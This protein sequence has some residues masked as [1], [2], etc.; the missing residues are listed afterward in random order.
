M[1][2]EVHSIY[3]KVVTMSYKYQFLILNKILTFTH[4]CVELYGLWPY[5]I[6]K[7]NRQIKYNYSKVIYSIVLPCILLSFFVIA[8]KSFFK[9]ARSKMGFNG[10]IVEIIS[11]A[12][13]FLFVISYVSV[14]IGQHLESNKTKLAYIK[15]VE[16]MEYLKRFPNHSVDFRK[17]L[18]YF[19]LKALVLELLFFSLFWFNLIRNTQD[20]HSNPYLPLLMY[21]P[22]VAIKLYTNIF[23]GGIL[24]LVVILKQLNKNLLHIVMTMNKTTEIHS[25]FNETY[26]R[27]SD[28]VDKL[29]TLH[30]KLNE[31]TRAF[32]SCFNFQILLWMT[33]QLCV[34]IVRCFNQYIGLVQLIGKTE[35]LKPTVI[36]NIIVLGVTIIS[37]LD[38]FTTSFAC[39]EL[40]TEVLYC[41]FSY[42]YIKL[43]AQ[44]LCY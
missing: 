17:Y 9:E 15:C 6:D 29:S 2:L 40:L 31:A 32:N 18:V 44:F 36:Q 14:Y 23:Y 39:E 21:S 10:L 20:V 4:F 35:N 33:T 27:I 38:L 26:C 42:L 12:Y 34:L 13:F 8:G 24:L 41:I 3:E 7:L 11:D 16:V 28:E 5:R 19:L 30:F 43:F 22:I 37:S 25:N 1:L